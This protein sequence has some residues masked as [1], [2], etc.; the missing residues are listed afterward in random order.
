MRRERDQLAL[1]QKIDAMIDLVKELLKEFGQRVIHP[2]YE[3]DLVREII[4]QHGSM[5]N[6]ERRK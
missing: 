5:S 6:L 1:K 2:I 4:S 3:D